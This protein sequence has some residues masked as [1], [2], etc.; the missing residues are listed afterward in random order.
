M[1]KLFDNFV[2]LDG[3]KNRSVEGTGLGL[4]ITQR[5]SQLMA[6][7]IEVQSVYG[8]GSTFTFKLPQKILEHK[9]VG[10]LERAYELP[11]TRQN[12]IVRFTAADAQILVVDDIASNLMV[13]EGIMAPYK[14]Q[15]KCCS[16]GSEA[17]KLASQ[18]RF[19]IIFM[20]HLMPGMDGIEATASIRKLNDNTGKDYYQKLPIIALTAN[21][22]SG[23]QEMFLEKGF[24][25]F[26]SKP[27]E[28]AKLDKIISQWIPK[29][30]QTR[31]TAEESAATKENVATAQKGERKPPVIEGVDTA[32][33]IANCAGS[34]D[35]YQTVLTTFNSEMQKWLS[36]FKDSLDKIP[37]GFSTEEFRAFTIQA[38]GL[39]S[40]SGNIGASELSKEAALLEE[41]GKAENAGV[42]AAKLP[43]FFT[44]LKQ[45][46]V[47]L[48]H[49][50]DSEYT[51]HVGTEDTAAI[52]Q[53][54][55]IIKKGGE[56]YDE[57][58][59]DGA[60]VT[61]KA[62][63]L[64]PKTRETLERISLLLLHSEFEEIEKAASR[65]LSE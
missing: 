31:I 25:D 14:M 1:K 46:A 2:R 21:A 37:G 50:C 24:T 34:L 55:E 18:K 27:I 19:D 23:M 15:V 26:L 22:I 35:V 10:V 3:D 5:L 60:I 47:Q 12:D 57:K 4:A 16:S 42:L 65:F 58:A 44:R 52:K 36:F 62:Q 54:F 63:S 11:L 41:A 45:L 7:S 64:K 29:H 17:I 48:K 13:A 40:A 28:I 8:Q 53:Q 6:G 33:G 49:I 9:P 43:D 59:I 61:L 51:Q 30:K 39:K 56:A 20:D 32:H 38:H